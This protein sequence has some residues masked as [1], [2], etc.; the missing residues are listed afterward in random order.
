MLRVYYKFNTAYFRE[1]DW[2]QLRD[3]FFPYFLQYKEEALDIKEKNPIDFM[4][5]IE[6]HFWRAT[7]LHLDGLRDFTAWIKQGSYYHGVVAQQGHLDKCPH[8]AGAPVPMWP[9]IMPSES[10]WESQKQ[11][12]TQT[13][14]SSEPNAGATTA[15]VTETPACSNTPTPMETGG[16]GDGQSW[17]KCI[18]AGTDKGFQRDRPVKRP[19]SQSRRHEPRLP[20][21]FPFQDSEGRL[22]SVLQLYEHAAEQ[23]VT[24]HNVAGRGIMHLHPEMLPQKARHLGNQVACMIAEYHLTSS[25]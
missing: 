14:S 12:D 5:Y 4:L 24:H 22:A 1:A 8:L 13:T 3:T 23:P 25:A 2:V 21:P 11:V 20:L 17:A 7:G 19:R 10:H 15:P 18:E 6:D 9:Q 16:A